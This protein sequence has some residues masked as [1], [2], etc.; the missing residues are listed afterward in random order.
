MDAHKF[1]PLHNGVIHPSY[2]PTPV[3]VFTSYI[4]SYTV[5]IVTSMTPSEITAGLN[6]ISSSGA[7]VASVRE[8]LPT[9]GVSAFNTPIG[10]CVRTISGV[11]LQKM[12]DDSFYLSTIIAYIAFQEIQFLNY[13]RSSS[14]KKPDF[15]A[16]TLTAYSTN[17]FIT[18]FLQLNKYFF[19]VINMTPT[20]N[21][22][23][24]PIKANKVNYSYI[25]F[26]ALLVVPLCAG[27]AFYVTYNAK[28]QQSNT[29]LDVKP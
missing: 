7:L 12:S 11:K 22:T 27:A 18:F 25:G 8:A 6:N 15:S 3:P 24:S 17:Y 13:F 16:D 20:I 26:L 9:I 21:P 14:Y 10:T 23:N 28:K 29:E 4:V 5:S 2:A 1:L 19:V